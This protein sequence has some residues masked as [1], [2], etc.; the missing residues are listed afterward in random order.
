MSRL[1][2]EPL[3]DEITEGELAAIASASATGWIEPP[4]YDCLKPEPPRPWRTVHLRYLERR[5]MVAERRMRRDGMLCIRLQGWVLVY[6]QVPRDAFTYR[7]QT[8][9]A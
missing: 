1:R 7:P 8:V 9:A 4:I 3:P 2:W 6:S 5:G